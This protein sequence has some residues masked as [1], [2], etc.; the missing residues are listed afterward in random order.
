MMGKE[1]MRAWLFTLISEEKDRI[2]KKLREKKLSLIKF[3]L[4]M[5]SIQF[6]KNL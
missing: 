5:I 6:L 3:I 2:Q 1:L 4:E